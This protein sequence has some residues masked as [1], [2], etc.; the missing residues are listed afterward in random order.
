MSHCSNF[1]STTCHEEYFH[2]GVRSSTLLY[3][4][5]KLTQ[6]RCSNTLKLCLKNALW[7]QLRRCCQREGPRCPKR[8]GLGDGHHLPCQLNPCLLR[9]LFTIPAELRCGFPSSWGVCTAVVVESVL[10]RWRKPAQAVLYT[11]TSLA[12]AR[13]LWPTK[14]WL[15]PFTFWVR[16]WNL[17]F[18]SVEKVRPFQNT[19]QFLC[20]KAV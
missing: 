18:R 11:A 16:G 1:P 5:S 7:I 2:F 12:R 20:A 9:R 6:E 15:K 13:L 10:G 14:V 17:T 4:A 8:Q 3:H 19:C